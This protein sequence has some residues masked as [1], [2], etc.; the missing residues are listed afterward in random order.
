MIGAEPPTLHQRE[1]SMNPRQHI[2]SD[3]TFCWPCQVGDDKAGAGMKIPGMPLDL[4]YHLTGFLPALRLITKAGV[5]AVHLVRR[6]PYW[7]FGRCSDLV[8]QNPIG[9]LFAAVLIAFVLM[10]DAYRADIIS[11]FASGRAHPGRRLCGYPA[12]PNPAN[13]RGRGA[14]GLWGISFDTACTAVGNGLLDCA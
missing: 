10:N 1:D 11:A 2:E 9:V 8:L 12:L 7:A 6:S 13:V 4:R 14:E 3:D 5:E